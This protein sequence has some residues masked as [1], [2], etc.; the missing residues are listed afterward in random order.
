LA[1][2]AERKPVMALPA[3]LSVE[4]KLAI[5]SGK[6]KKPILGGPEIGANKPTLRF[7]RLHAFERFVNP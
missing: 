6:Q 2:I 3:V 7:R 4:A 5:R 1:P